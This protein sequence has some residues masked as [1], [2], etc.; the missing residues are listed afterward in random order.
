M[1][2]HILQL[3]FAFTPVFILFAQ[4]IFPLLIWTWATSPAGEEETWLNTQ[5]YH[6]YVRYNHILHSILEIPY[7]EYYIIYLSEAEGV[8]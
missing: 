4:N 1:V 5:Q 8:V 3:A 2:S 6:K 7:N